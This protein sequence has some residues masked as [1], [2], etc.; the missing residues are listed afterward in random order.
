VPRWFRGAAA[1]LRIAL[2]IA[3]SARW[4]PIPPES[5]RPEPRAAERARGRGQSSPGDGHGR[6]LLGAHGD[7]ALQVVQLAE[8]LPQRA[9]ALEVPGYVDGA[10]EG[11]ERRRR[12]RKGPPR[13]GERVRQEPA[14]FVA[15]S[16]G[17]RG[18]P[19]SG[20][21]GMKRPCQ[22]EQGLTENTC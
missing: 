12:R 15:G 5:A 21:S 22:K 10:L 2:R 1:P 7:A 9:A 16:A 13:L 14:R 19:G 4:E 20:S 18:R 17:R 6:L 11:K 3:G 8:V